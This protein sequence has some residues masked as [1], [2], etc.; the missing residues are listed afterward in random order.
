[1]LACPVH[2]SKKYI[3]KKY[4]DNL[5]KISY[6]N[7]ACL[8]VDNSKDDKFANYIKKWGFKVLRD[9]VWFDT[10][11][12]RQCF[13]YN[14]IR[15]YFLE[16]DYEFLF[17]LESDLIPKA[18]IIEQLMK[19]DKDTCA[20]VY[21]LSRNKGIFCLTINEYIASNGGFSNAFVKTGFIDG[22][23]K[24][25]SNGCGFGCVLIKRKVLEK[26][27][28]RFASQHADSYFWMD[29]RNYGF[30]PYVDTGIIVPH[31]PGGHVVPIH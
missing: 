31:Y 18:D 26:I 17:I 30:R 8:F 7:L 25:V 5:L 28:F 12:Q 9:P 21:L 4:F 22:G 10:S 15:D 2:D 14:R 23:L 29:A 11:R 19:H 24:W 27:R 1:L 20:A 3:A 13:S 16:G 6:P